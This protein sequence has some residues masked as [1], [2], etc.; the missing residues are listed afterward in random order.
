[1][2]FGG[3]AAPS[4]IGPESGIVYQVLVPVEGQGQFRELVSR[5]LHN[6]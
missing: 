2:T 6:C 5:D 1:M 3:H 4:S